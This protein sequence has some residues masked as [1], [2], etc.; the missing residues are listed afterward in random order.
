MAD[1]MKSSSAFPSMADWF[2]RFFFGWPI[3]S[4]EGVTWAPR[5]DVHETDK[6]IH[7]Y[8]DLPG[9]NK[10]DIK[11]EIKNNVL[12]I[13]G[14]RKQMPKGEKAEYSRVERNY[15]KFERSFG[16]P[17]IVNTDSI[18]ANYKDGVLTVTLQKTE[19]AMPKKIAVEVK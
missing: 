19:K 7:L 14:E 12:T 5:V 13:S 10:D 17:D 8:I 15:G 18:G 16:L 1:I 3:Y 4:G 9:V 6:E 2:D 11:V